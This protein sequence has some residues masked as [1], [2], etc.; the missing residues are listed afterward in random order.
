MFPLKKIKNALAVGL[1]CSGLTLEGKLPKNRT[2]PIGL[3]EFRKKTI[4]QMKRP[5]D[6]QRSQCALN[7]I[8]FAA[9]YTFRPKSPWHTNA[10]SLYSNP[11]KGSSYQLSIIAP[12]RLSNLHTWR[13]VLMNHPCKKILRGLPDI[14]WNQSLYSRL[15][16]RIPDCHCHRRL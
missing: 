12:V 2:W 7:S 16:Y 10:R 1:T 3:S 14:S 13:T 4:F 15:I 5:K 6:K 8:I 9:S 11:K